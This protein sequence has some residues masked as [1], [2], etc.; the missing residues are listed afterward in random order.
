[1]KTKL[2][3]ILFTV[4]VL[5]STTGL[6]S[7]AQNTNPD[8]SSK[9]QEEKKII[10][11]RNFI[12]VNLTGILVKNY[13]VQYERILSRKFSFSL[14]YRVMPTTTLPFQSYILKSVGNDNPE[15]AK[16]IKNF[17]LSNY[18]I[19]PELRFYVSK[20][21]FG[22]GFYIAPF[23]RYAS[24]KTD[25]LNIFYTDNA[26]AQSSSKLSGKLTGNS[27]GILFGVQ[28]FFGKHIV[29]DTWIFGPHYGSAKGEFNGTS[30]KPFTQDEQNDLRDQLNNID[31]P[32]TNKTVNVDASRASLK[33]DGPWGG[34]RWGLSLGVKF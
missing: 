24:F 30:T 8:T 2:F 3:I 11:D 31:I 29:L 6:Q 21:G 26:G 23:Y 13:S 1:M 25:N 20:K 18:A 19:T 5:L 14:S 34:L 22:R 12:K 33:L 4:T 17:K 9:I 27:G 7:A 32:L 16:T 28:R 10:P 15:T